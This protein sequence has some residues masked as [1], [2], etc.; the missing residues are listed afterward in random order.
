MS[1]LGLPPGAPDDGEVPYPECECDAC[2]PEGV[3]RNSA[4]PRVHIRHRMPFDTPCDGW[5][6]VAL[7]WPRLRPVRVLRGDEFVTVAMEVHA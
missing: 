6:Y 3:P 7:G 5:R 2:R 1:A 4:V